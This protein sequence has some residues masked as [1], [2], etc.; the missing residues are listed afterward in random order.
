[1]LE[2]QVLLAM[3]M[4]WLVVLLA[5]VRSLHPLNQLY[6]EHVTGG[7]ANHSHACIFYYNLARDIPAILAISHKVKQSYISWY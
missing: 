5:F 4:E 7:N 1:M 3:A 2:W 6:H